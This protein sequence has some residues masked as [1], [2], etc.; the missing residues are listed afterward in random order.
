MLTARLQSRLVPQGHPNR[1]G[2]K[3]TQVRALV[4]HWTANTSR[5]AN[6]AANAS[7]F[8]RKY[9]TIGGKYYEMSNDEKGNPKPF[10]QAS[11]HY[12]VDSNGIMTAIPETEVAFHVGAKS[13]K[14]LAIERFKMSN[15]L[16]RPNEFCI[17]IEMCVNSDGDWNRTVENTLDLASEIMIRYGLNISQVIMHHDVTGKNCPKMYVDDPRAWADFK[18]KLAKKVNEKMTPSPAPVAQGAFKDVPPTHWAFK[19][20]DELS[21]SGI[22]R[23]DENGDFRPDD[24]VSRAELAT[25]I[26]R[27][28]E[29]LN[30]TL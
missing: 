12:C 19:Y 20:I 6:A 26:G 5:G 21:K 30:L 27:L 15:G 23:A 16:V 17:G 28:L 11:A 22:F 9:R 7:Y 10:S 4:I 24:K 1:P 3:I 14:A 29:K 2:R 25:V 18:A 13:Y 8:A